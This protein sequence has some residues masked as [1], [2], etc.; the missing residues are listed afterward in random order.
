VTVGCGDLPSS[1]STALQLV[2]DAITNGRAVVREAATVG[3]APRTKLGLTVPGAD[4][5]ARVS[6]ARAGRQ[7]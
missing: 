3:A 2:D 6:L 5:V 4:I 7:R 1:T